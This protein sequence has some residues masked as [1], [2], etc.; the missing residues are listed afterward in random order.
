MIY[1]KM[2]SLTSKWKRKKEKTNAILNEIDGQWAADVVALLK[3][4]VTQ[5]RDLSFFIHRT[6]NLKQTLND[7]AQR[8]PLPTAC[9]SQ[10]ELL[11]FFS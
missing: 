9:V 8:P 5:E 1:S 11:F 4:Y 7:Q 2:Y 6:G 3:I 10:V